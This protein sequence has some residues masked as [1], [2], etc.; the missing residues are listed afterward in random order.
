MLA[1]LI[2]TAV[3]SHWASEHASEGIEKQLHW[4]M[5]MLFRDD[6]LPRP[7][8]SRASQFHHH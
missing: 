4:V 6:E 8:Q 3:R 2:G 7:D 5:D 1:N